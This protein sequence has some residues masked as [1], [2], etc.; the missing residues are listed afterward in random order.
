[1][2]FESKPTSEKPLNSLPYLQRML[3]LFLWELWLGV[4]AK[5][6]NF[7]FLKINL[8]ILIGGYLLYNIV[9]IFAMHWHKSAM[10]VHVFPILNPPP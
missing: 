8:F 5:L 2:A 6:L 4:T 7:F 1:M 9:V 10:G 3:L